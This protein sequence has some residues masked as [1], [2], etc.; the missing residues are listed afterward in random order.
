MVQLRIAS[1]LLR[2]LLLACMAAISVHPAPLRFTPH[3]WEAPGAPVGESAHQ[4]AYQHVR[5][6]YRLDRKYSEPA[7]QLVCSPFDHRLCPVS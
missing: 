6:Y 4:S 2:W 7:M 5:S 1:I 3:P